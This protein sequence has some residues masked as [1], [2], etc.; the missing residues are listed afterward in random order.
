[1]KKVM[2]G[3]LVIIPV[4]IVLVVALVSVFV[5]MRT[6]IAVDDIT[7]EISEQYKQ[8]NK[9]YLE[10]EYNSADS[11]YKLSDLFDVTITPDRASN[12]NYTWSIENLVCIDSEYASMWKE[13]S[14]P[15]PA[16]VHNSVDVSRE[17]VLG[18]IEDS[19]C[20]PEGYLHI[21]TYCSFKLKVQAETHTATCF[22]Y[23]VGF[24]VEKIEIN[25][26][27]EMAIGQNALLQVETDP[28]E[29]I[30]DTWIYTSSNT[31]VVTVDS[32][33]VINAVGAGTST[34]TVKASVFGE[35]NKFVSKSVT[36]TVKDGV[37]LYGNNIVTSRDEILFSQLGVN[38]DNV[39][40]GVGAE[41]NSAGDGIVITDD[42]AII[43]VNGTTVSIIKCEE[44]AIIIDNANLFE[45]QESGGYVLPTGGKLYLT[46][47]FAD[48]FTTGRPDVTWSSNRPSIA[49]VSEDGTVTG[50]SNG[51][52]EITA[53][54]GD[55]KSYTFTINVRE[56]VT[57][58]LIETP[59]EC[60]SAGIAGETI[61][62]SMV[63]V[64]LFANVTNPD[65]YVPKL[66]D[67]N[68]TKKDNSFDFKFLRPS[69]PENANEE[70]F[71]S[72]FD[73]KVQEYQGSGD[74]RVLVDTDKA[75][76]D[77]NTLIF[78][79]VNIDSYSELIVTITAKYP[80][81]P[82][83]PEYTTVQ[84]TVKVTKGVNITSWAEMLAVSDEN[85]KLR[86]ANSNARTY[87]MCLAQNIQRADGFRPND[88]LITALEAI[89]GKVGAGTALSAEEEALWLENGESAGLDYLKRMRTYT[90]DTSIHL[91]NNLYGNGHMIYGYKEQYHGT[92][93]DQ[94]IRIIEGGVTVSNV[95]IRSCEVGDI[96]VDDP[97]DTSGLVGNC[98]RVE[99]IN[100]GN[101]DLR[102]E[103]NVIEFCILENTAT[104]L[105]IYGSDITLD[106]CIARNTSETAIYTPIRRNG[107]KVSY[108]H[109]TI[110]N[111]V[112]SNMLATAMTVRFDGFVK[113]TD[114]ASVE[115][116]L[117][118]QAEGR[119]FVLNQTGFWDIYNWQSVNV[120][121]FLDAIDGLNGLDLNGLIR[122]A[123]EESDKFSEYSIMVED[124]EYFHLG[125][126]I[127][128]FGSSIVET[129]YPVYSFEDERIQMVNSQELFE[130]AKGAASAILGS[131]KP[132]YMF[133]YGHNY[134]EIGP[135]STYE[136]DKNLIRHLHGEI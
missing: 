119:T 100:S 78:N 106:G 62:G 63:Y 6:H 14:A 79:S 105:R 45:A 82:S 73:F 40:I 38:K 81:F 83:R 34:V 52:A 131:L 3:I 51:R 133:T 57:V 8:P 70:E 104:A 12:K 132:I 67:F 65:T 35:T 69:L 42:I 32:N 84:F 72:A 116:A 9:D 7:L 25:C 24:K 28:V 18:D 89:N 33:G 125:F 128:G 87:D 111:C 95:I 121:N 26:P 98:I 77:G 15:A 80:K 29:A 99:S 55:G 56:I 86:K 31:D 68:L 115:R 21:N 22:V 118:D 13:G 30:V 130:G 2:I 50:V 96:I 58:L 108:T 47:S 60:E 97:E 113:D 16:F 90:R 74:D 117:K 19:T 110:N 43:D 136:V 101:Y 5:S 53:T 10:L 66:A 75:R 123:L 135:G 11:I 122:K 88:E 103:N 61:N 71:Y 102:L 27:T 64:N 129:P 114:P 20:G 93:G 126:L 1:M 120:L 49:Q 23:V 46:A 54:T 109:L 85:Y 41:L 39:T 92:T 107:D 4:I 91:R 124:E 94:N 112:F 37:T 134:G 59:D 44:G 76:F 36:I 17:E 48:C 127:A